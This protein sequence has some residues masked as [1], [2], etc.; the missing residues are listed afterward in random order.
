MELGCR[1]AAYPATGDRKVKGWA[2]RIKRVARPSPAPW[3]VA[4][5]LASAGQPGGGRG[6]DGG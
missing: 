5:E 1:E 6:G 4:V 2:T 3:T